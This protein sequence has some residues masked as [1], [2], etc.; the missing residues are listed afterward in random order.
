[1]RNKPVFVTLFSIILIVYILFGGDSD[2]V[3]FL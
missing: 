3:S 1:M 2:A